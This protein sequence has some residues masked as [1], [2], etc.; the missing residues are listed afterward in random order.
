MNNE[1]TVGYKE[2]INVIKRGKWIIL[3]LTLLLTLTA[4]VFSFY[5]MKSAKPI[6]QT[7]IGVIIGEKEDI[8]NAKGLISTFEEIASSSTIAKNTSKALNGSVSALEVQKSYEVSVADG[9]PIL[10]II[11][12]GKSQKESVA[13]ANA[14]YTSFTK[15]V[16]RIYPTQTMKIMEN[17]AQ[18][19]LVNNKFKFLNVVLA[20]LL[21]LFLS[22]FIVTFTGYF[23]EKI[24][25]KDD[26]EKYLGLDVIGNLPK[27][28]KTDI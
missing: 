6:Y 22:I 28:K 10:T 27:R 11:A 8:V 3:L 7:K 12:S 15:E 16:K 14:V 17:S 4:T 1:T 19:G 18:N 25:T 13:I 9:A 20:F 24:R 2:F 26:V 23:D 21:G 5:L